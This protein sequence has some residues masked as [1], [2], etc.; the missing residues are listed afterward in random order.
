MHYLKTCETIFDEPGQ[1]ED[2]GAHG[3]HSAAAKKGSSSSTGTPGPCARRTGLLVGAA[4]KAPWRSPCSWNLP[5]LILM[6]I[7]GEGKNGPRVQIGV[8]IVQK[9]LVG[10]RLIEIC[11][12][13][14]THN[15][16]LP[17][18]GSLTGGGGRRR[19]RSLFVNFS[20][21]YCLCKNASRF[22]QVELVFAF[23]WTWSWLGRCD[24]EVRP[25][26]MKQDGLCHRGKQTLAVTAAVVFIYRPG[27]LI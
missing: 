17:T 11:R 5:Y 1:V 26:P 2:P 19:R 14:K 7:D 4:G 27:L 3:E 18:V 8:K 12:Q 16:V 25:K 13:L 9:G 20:R 24:D 22:G 21:V 10:W 6:M 23:A 15:L